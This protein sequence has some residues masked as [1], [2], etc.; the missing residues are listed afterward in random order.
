MTMKTIENGVEGLSVGEYWG[1]GF[2]GIHLGDAE[3]V[4]IDQETQIRPTGGGEARTETAM[5]FIC[6]ACSLNLVRLFDVGARDWELTNG[7]LGL[8]SDV[9]QH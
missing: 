7:K 9:A 5:T 3:V 2:C 6:E 4:A 1:A 8:K